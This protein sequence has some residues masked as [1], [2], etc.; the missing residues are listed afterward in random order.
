MTAD[1]IQQEFTTEFLEWDDVMEK[2]NEIPI[3]KLAVG[4]GAP[5]ALKR[6]KKHIDIMDKLRAAAAAI[7][8][9]AFVERLDEE[10]KTARAEMATLQERADL[11]AQVEEPVVVEPAPVAPV[12]DTSEVDRLMAE[13]EALTAELVAANARAE[14]VKAE[15]D[16]LAAQLAAGKL[17]PSE[18]E[19]LEAA[20]M[21]KD[22]ELAQL[23]SAFD[24]SRQTLMREM[25][26]VKAERD[27]LAAQVAQGTAT[28]S[29]RETLKAA[30]AAKDAELA[31]LKA[32]YESSRR[33]LVDEYEKKLKSAATSK[34][35]ALSERDK[36]VAK[37]E[38]LARRDARYKRMAKRAADKRRSK[39][40]PVSAKRLKR[41]KEVI[42]KYKRK[43]RKGRRLAR[44]R[45]TATGKRREARKTATTTTATTTTAPT[46]QRRL[47]SPSPRPPKP[48]K[49]TT[50]APRPP[51]KSSK[52][53]GTVQLQIHGTPVG[54]VDRITFAKGKK[55]RVSKGGKPVK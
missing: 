25:E 29:E 3:E 46:R 43:A 13:K 47:P 21:A 26:A 51:S 31:K 39:R 18:R 14:A 9:T 15:R 6:S 2:Y 48:P 17:A 4:E 24:S 12:P 36:A 8:E 41:A 37:L 27:D 20:L 16:D 1:E 33:T 28:A 35:S 54:G 19:T 30:L 22:A 11:A 40:K 32:T 53:L 10:L 38:W 23:Q 45:K 52:L 50:V 49:K 55:A 42:T 5:A 7:D 44:E 34:K